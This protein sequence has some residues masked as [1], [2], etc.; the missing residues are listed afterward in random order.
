MND[1]A[2]FST[3]LKLF[4]RITERLKTGKF[5][6]EPFSVPDSYRPHSIPMIM[7]NISG[8]MTG[9]AEKLKHPEIE[10]LQKK[11]AG[12]MEDIMENFY[13]ADHRVAEMVPLNDSNK[14]SLLYRHINPGHAIESMWFVMETARKNRN[15]DYIH[16][17]ALAI[18]RALNAGWDKKFGGLFR[19]VDKNGGNPT[20][21][22]GSSFYEKLITDTWD[23][24]LWWP[25]SE[26]LYATLLGYTLTGNESLIQWH[27]RIQEYVFEIFPNPDRAIGEWIQI[28]SRNGTPLD[29]VAALPVKDPFHILRNLLLIIDIL[30]E[31]EK[32]KK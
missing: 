28:R 25:H 11:S 22:K 3:A 1:S 27:Q 21:E 17:A 23:M 19:F 30:E 13:Q 14:N 8:E 5:R 9:S 32:I 18:E 29:K 31:E 6:S 7:L 2:R 16:K 12:Y 24:K 15:N 26:A 20:G 4:N 10:S